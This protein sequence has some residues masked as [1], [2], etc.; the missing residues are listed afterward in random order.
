MRIAKTVA[1]AKEKAEVKIS[2][3]VKEAF[4]EMVMEEED[5]LDDEDGIFM[6]ELHHI[7][8]SSGFLTVST[9]GGML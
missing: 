2:R 8:K 5:L 1:S 9:I 6:N 3:E 4:R 7:Y